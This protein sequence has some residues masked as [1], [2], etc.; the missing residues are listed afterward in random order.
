LISGEQNGEKA[1]RVLVKRNFL[2][3]GKSAEKKAQKR[4]CGRSKAVLGWVI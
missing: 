3:A 2:R 1:L 4:A